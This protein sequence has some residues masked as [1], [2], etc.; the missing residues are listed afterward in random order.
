MYN[1]CRAY[2]PVSTALK[3]LYEGRAYRLRMTRYEQRHRWLS[4]L[5]DCYALIDLSVWQAV[6][7]ASDVLACREGCTACCRHTIP[8]STL[9]ALGLRFYVHTLLDAALYQDLRRNISRQGSLCCFNHQGSCTVYALRPI[10]CRRYLV[11]GT[12]CAEDESP[13]DSR[14]HAVLHPSRDVLRRAVALTLPFYR[15]IGLKPESGE[16]VLSFYLRKNMPL[17]SLNERIFAGESY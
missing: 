4:L 7:T 6:D 14:P 13:L 1:P 16:D 9:E 8:L 3:S 10:A 5:L 17:T 11:T 2:V 15:T 12:A